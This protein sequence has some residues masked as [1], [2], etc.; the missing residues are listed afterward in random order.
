ME[1]MGRGWDGG[2]MEGPALSGAVTGAPPLD[3]EGRR[4][5]GS[6]GWKKLR[7]C[8]KGADYLCQS[9]KIIKID[10]TQIR[11]NT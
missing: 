6:G 3:L 10:C 5:V 8:C 2:M 1:W 4:A 7:W 9:S 11:T